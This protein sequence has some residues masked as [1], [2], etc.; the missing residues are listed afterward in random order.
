MIERKEKIKFI[1]KSTLKFSKYNNCSYFLK[2][3]KFE[4]SNLKII[5]LNKWVYFIE[6]I[7]IWKV[8]SIEF[9]DL[10]LQK[11][12][13]YV[14]IPKLLLSHYHSPIHLRKSLESK[15]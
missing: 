4:I 11:Q 8:I 6:Q 1:F 15:N 5:D 9:L 14:F 13:I 7:E 10:F 12:N 2:K 3:T